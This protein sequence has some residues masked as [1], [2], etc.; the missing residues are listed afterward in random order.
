MQETS[1]L[2]KE[3][4]S[5]PHSKEIRLACGAKAT[6][7]GD[8]STFYGMDTLVSIGT[9]GRLFSEDF[10]VVGCCVGAEISAKMLY[11]EIQPPRQAKLVP[12]VRLTDE[13]RYS[14]WISKGVF[15]TDTRIR[16]EHGPGLETLTLTGYDAMLMT[17]QDYPS[18]SLAWPAKDIDVV[19]EIAAFIGVGV[20]I[21]T[22]EIMDK[23]YP[24]QYPGGEYTCR[25]TLGFIAA[26]Y[27]GSFIMNDIGELRLVQLGGIPKAVRVLGNR[28]GVPITFGGELIRV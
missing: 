24:I 19:R 25:E 13:S 8:L 18:S 16:K 23:G 20:D 21:R 26:M 17:E 11:P 10:P 14:E 4:L 5:L 15:F 1:A 3:L 12:Q 22:V 6:P 2:Y 7:I 27:G 28:S 9:A